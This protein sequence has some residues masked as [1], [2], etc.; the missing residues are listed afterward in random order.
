M[1]V[2]KK[3]STQL[4]NKHLKH[5]LSGTICGYTANVNAYQHLNKH[6]SHPECYL[7]AGFGKI[8]GYFSARALQMFYF[9]HLNSTLN[10][11]L[12]LIYFSKKKFSPY[13]TLPT[14]S[15]CS[16]YF[17][18]SPYTVTFPLFTD[19]CASLKFLPVSGLEPRPWTSLA[20]G[21]CLYPLSCEFA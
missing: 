8:Q 7:K 19:I 10:A 4:T 20:T 14:S 11:D 18:L 17:H 16:R 5:H 9:W 15:L 6:Y 2:D 3:K 21:W 12:V 1:Q 13:S